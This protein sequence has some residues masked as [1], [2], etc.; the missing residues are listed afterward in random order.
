MRG[1]RHL[2]IITLNNL[3]VIMKEFIN[4]GYQGRNFQFRWR[5]LSKWAPTRK[6]QE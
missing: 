3:K 1:T 5:K 6:T 2:S 4:M